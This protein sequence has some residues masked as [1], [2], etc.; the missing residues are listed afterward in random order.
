MNFPL[1]A[2]LMKTYCF[3]EEKQAP[4]VYFPAQETLTF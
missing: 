2:M 4:L 3:T 1:G